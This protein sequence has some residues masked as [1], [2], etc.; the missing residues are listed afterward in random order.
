VGIRAE[1]RPSR[2]IEGREGDVPV[3]RDVGEAARREVG[4]AA[5]R[6]E[7]LRDTRE[8]LAGGRALG[9][10]ALDAEHGDVRGLR[11]RAEDAERAL[12]RLV[13]RVARN[14]EL[15]EPALRNLL[16]GE[17]TENREDD[18]ADRHEAAVPHDRARKP[19]QGALSRR[20]SLEYFWV[21]V[22]LNS[23]V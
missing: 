10:V 7:L 17:R 21:R 12:V 19:G 11:S 6:R 16:C 15:L 3:A 2:W 4:R 20:L 22:H 18:P 8:R 23:S 1:A 14:R 5:E 13:G 9:H